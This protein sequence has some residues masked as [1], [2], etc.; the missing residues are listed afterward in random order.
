MCWQSLSLTDWSSPTHILFIWNSLFLFLLLLLLLLLSLLSPLCRVFTII[1]LKQTMLLG[2]VVVQL[3][4]IYYLL[5]HVMLFR[6]W[7]MFCTFTLALLRSMC[8]VSNMAACFF[9][10][11]ISC[12]RDMLLRYCLGDFEMVPVTPVITGITFAFTFHMCWISIMRALYY[13]YYYYYYYMPR[14]PMWFPP[15]RFFNK[16]FT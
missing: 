11:L 7:N 14:L 15:P 4:C 13:Y 2:Y 5:L 1:Y 6:Q 9:S 16:N 8:A 3:Y 10:S 12:F